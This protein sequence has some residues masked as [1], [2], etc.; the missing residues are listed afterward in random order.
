M[1][2]A[3]NRA[4]PG[5]IADSGEA[6]ADSGDAFAGRVDAARRDVSVGREDAARRDAVR[7]GTSLAPSNIQA[8]IGAGQGELGLRLEMSAGEGAAGS[9][10]DSGEVSVDSGV[11][12]TGR[13]DAARWEDASVGC[14]DAAR[15]DMPH[16]VMS[17]APFAVQA[18]ARAGGG[19]AG[20]RPEPSTG[21]RTL[22]R[23]RRHWNPG[24]RRRGRIPASGRTTPFA[25]SCCARTRA[26]RRRARNSF[27]RTSR[28]CAF[29]S[30]ALPGAARTWRICFN[31]A[32]WGSSR[33]STGL[34]LRFPC[35][36]R[37]MPCRSSSARSGGFFATTGRFT[38]RAPFTRTPA[39][40]RGSA[41]N[42]APGTARRPTS[43]AWPRRSR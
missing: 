31:T 29:W 13:V 41:M 25:K 1:D 15:R 28:W 26:M 34:I 4:R 30:S 23:T 43:D 42:G 39:A 5:S 12:P 8:G 37:R 2:T 20:L 7:A 6:S 35:G 27:R 19:D 14:E 16:D 17:F 32:A 10:A 24:R 40:W 33:R 21:R 9:I 3:E 38:S 18:C 22:A 36:F 11:A